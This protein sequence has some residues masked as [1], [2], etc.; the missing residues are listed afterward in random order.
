MSK[1]KFALIV[2]ASRGLGLAIVQEL[3][4]RGWKEKNPADFQNLQDFA[5]YRYL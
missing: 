3:L 2:G 1:H 4:E 5:F